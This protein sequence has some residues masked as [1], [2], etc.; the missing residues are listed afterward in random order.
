MVLITKDEFLKFKTRQF[1]NQ[2]MFEWG[3]AA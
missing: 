2:F 1:L 3:E